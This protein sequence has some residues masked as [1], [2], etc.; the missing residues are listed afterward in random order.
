MY[1]STKKGFQKLRRISHNLFQK[2][3]LHIICDVICDIYYMYVIAFNSTVF[4]IEIQQTL[5]EI[6]YQ[7]HI[8]FYRVMGL[9]NS[10]SLIEVTVHADPPLQ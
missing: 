8:M 5:F 4:E 2:H 3:C 7:L 10:L 1:E 9:V 6:E